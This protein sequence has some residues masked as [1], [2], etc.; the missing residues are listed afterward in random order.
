MITASAPKTRMRLA[1]AITALN[2]LV[3]SGFS[4]AGLFK[5]EYVLPAGSVQTD[6]SFIFAMYAAA[7]TLPLALMALAAIYQRSAS[8]LTVLGL[9][10]GLI[11]FCDGAVGLYQHD[12]GKIIGPL[13]LGALQMYAIWILPKD[14]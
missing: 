6:A 8:S 11:Q 10:A 14:S 3:A 13:V 12:I 4:I 1:S 7:R 2:V 9:L 5:P